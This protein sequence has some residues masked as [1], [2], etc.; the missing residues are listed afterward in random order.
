MTWMVTVGGRYARRP[1]LCDFLSEWARDFYTQA[2]MRGA[3]HDVRKSKT[4]FAFHPHGCL[5]AGWTINGTFNQAFTRRAGRVN[6]LI[7]PGLRN[8]NPTFRMLCDAYRRED[9]AI[10]AGDRQGFQEIMSR[11]ES[12]ALIPGGFQDAVVAQFGKDSCVVRKRKG[13][14]KYCLH[15][16]YRL[17]PVYTFGEC[18][19]YHTFT[20][21]RGLRIRISERNIPMVAFFGWPLCPLLPRPESRILTYVGPGIDLPHIASPTQE[22]VDHWHGV[23][24]SA[25]EK[26]FEDNKAD[27]GYPQASLEIL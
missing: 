1:A 6:W 25:L 19:T 22:E 12:V 11:G 27:A 20:G 5:S 7:D 23:Y 2:E 3:L 21:F 24:L 4:F 26:L 10:E 14:V 9:R 15:Y 17:H 13:F 18:E 16:G 8:K